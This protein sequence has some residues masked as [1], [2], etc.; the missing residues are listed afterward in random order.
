[1]FE[2]YTY[3]NIL[4]RMLDRIPDD[5]DK[6]EGS[7]I[8]DALS[9]AALELEFTYICLQYTL[10]Q[11]FAD[12]ADRDYLILRASERGIIPYPASCAVLKGVFTPSTVNVTGK[13][14]NLNA[15]NYV[16]GDPIPGEAGAYRV[17]CE[18]AGIIGHS[19]L[20]DLIPI[21]YVEGLETA[22]AT[23]ILIP[24]ENEETTEELRRRYYESFDD[25]AYGGNVRDYKDKVESIN[26]V[27]ACRVTPIWN[28]GGTVKCTI[29]DSEYNPASSALIDAVQ[30]IIDP[31]QD[32]EGYGVAPIGHIVTIDTASETTIN[33]NLNVEF[34]AGYSWDNMQSSVE[35]T[36]E[37]YMLE[38][39]T[40]WKNS[41]SGVATVVRISQIETRLLELDGILDIGGTTINGSAT[42]YSVTGNNI[43]VLGTVTHT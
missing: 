40:A 22:K 9:P 27:G 42:N 1:M 20:G 23:A 18:T 3:A 36:L 37:E 5:M 38:L 14:F 8:W 26:G 10:N 32:A 24:G 28:G 39:R 35:E 12:T 30:D 16:V 31:D 6:R 11:S 2:A 43:P 21:E 34:N 41:R 33:I 19:A 25:K 17:T 13:R 4:Q 7:V 15:L 29:L